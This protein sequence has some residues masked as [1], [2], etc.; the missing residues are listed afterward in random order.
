M[1][2]TQ[3]SLQVRARPPES[4]LAV[5]S[6]A[7]EPVTA[8]PVTPVLR[9]PRPGCDAGDT[10]APRGS[11]GPLRWPLVGGQMLL[12]VNGAFGAG[13]TTVVEALEAA[14]PGTITSPDVV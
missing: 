10:R 6:R 4:D 11:P 9:P 14:R 8:V 5:T 1:R 2:G 7:V 12:W 13:K 3:P